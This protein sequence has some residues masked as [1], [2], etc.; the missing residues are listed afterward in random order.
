MAGIEVRLTSARQSTYSVSGTVAGLDAAGAPDNLRIHLYSGS[1]SW[2]INTQNGAFRFAPV[3]PGK[4]AVYATAE[5]GTGKLRSAQVDI[6][7]EGGD[8]SN[9]Q[10]QLQPL[11]AMSGTIEI[12]GQS[13]KN[14]PKAK[15]IFEPASEGPVARVMAH[16]DVG[17]DSAFRLDAPLPGKYEVRLEPMPEN[18]YV[19][20]VEVDGAVAAGSELD[21][22]PASVSPRVKIT[23]ATDAGQ[24]SGKVL[25]KDGK[26][27]GVGMYAILCVPDGEEVKFSGEPPMA[28]QDGSYTVQGLRPG[29]YRLFAV[30]VFQFG[31]GGSNVM[32][33]LKKM[34]QAAELVEVQ[35]GGRVS[36]DVKVAERISK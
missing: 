26:L 12:A 22:T 21:L 33:E 6:R 24:I 30:D 8:V 34:A 5:S 10:L 20:S 13:A 15:V 32:E 25:D 31:G 28:G 1:S 17:A 4:Y 7:V 36:R 16:A 14:R 23:I 18:A 27:A 3:R 9:V 35:P 19:R 29:K 2:D 11:G